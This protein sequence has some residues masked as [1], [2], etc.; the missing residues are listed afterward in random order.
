MKPHFLELETSL[1][2]VD[3]FTH[4]QLYPRENCLGVWVDAEPVRNMEK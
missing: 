2:L 4:Q 1:R 3:S